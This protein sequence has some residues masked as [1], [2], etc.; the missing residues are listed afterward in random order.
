MN[1]L[2]RTALSRRSLLGGLGLGAAGLGLSACGAPGA[3]DTDPAKPVREGFQQADAP[4]PSKY[5]GRTPIVFWAPFTGVNFDAIVALFDAFNESQDEIVA[6]T[7]SQGSYAQLNQKFTASIQARAVPDIVCFP[8]FQWLQFYFAGALARLDEYFDDE[9]NLDV[10]IKNYIPESKAGG[11]TYVVPFARST[12]LFYFNRDRYAEAG[13]PEEGPKTWDDLAEFAPEL[14][15]L[16]VS[17]KDLRTVV[18]GA[19]DAWFAQADLWAFDTHSSVD[20]DVTINHDKAIEMLSWQRKFIHE[21]HFGYM[22]QSAATDFTTG[23]AAGVRGSTAQLRDLTDQA[24][25][26][27]GAAFMPGQVNQPTQVPTGGSG[28]S[29]VR[30]DSKD[31][32]DACAELFRFLAIPENSAAWHRDT[33]YVPIVEKAKDTK[34]VKDLVAENPNYKV[35][36]DQLVN[37]H[38]GDRASWFQSNVTEI[39]EGL[40]TVYGDNAD[41]Q[42]S[43]DKVAEVLQQKLDDSR[44][45]LEEVLQQ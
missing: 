24:G 31:R 43:M 37:A 44:E 16:Q 6:L 35:S 10:Y 40:A 38:T 15:K 25:F 33:G 1:R 2:S 29:I 42:A 9:W 22:A 18:F 21:D 45:D 17:G 34:I 32:Q 39:E 5:R 41:P 3:T 26:E 19:A 27:V 28:L 4:I 23:L 7:E 14:A 8:E 30:A 12:P 13:L 20:F 11:H 36:L